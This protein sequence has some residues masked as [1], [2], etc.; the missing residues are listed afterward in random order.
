MRWESLKVPNLDFSALFPLG[1]QV[2]D[3][4]GGRCFGC[5]EAYLAGAALERE[6]A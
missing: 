6:L 1:F 4:V 3:L 2:L 5:H